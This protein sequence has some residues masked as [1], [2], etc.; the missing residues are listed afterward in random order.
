MAKPFNK[1]TWI[2]STLRRA[3][4]RWPARNQ[5]EKAARRDRGLYECAHCKGLFRRGEYKLDHINPVVSLKDGFISWDLFIEGLFCDAANYQVLCTGCHDIKTSLE[6]E[7]RKLY[8]K[9]DKK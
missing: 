2:I 1:K 3:S 4:Y 7:M 6:K 5:A 8:G 9:K